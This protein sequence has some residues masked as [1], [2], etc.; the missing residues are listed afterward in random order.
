MNAS[1]RTLTVF[2]NAVQYSWSKIGINSPPEPGGNGNTFTTQD[3]YLGIRCYLKDA[4]GNWH[5][6]QALNVGKYDNQREGIGVSEEEENEQP[7]FELNAYPNPYTTNFT[8]TFDVP[9]ENSQV[10]LDIMNSQ[11]TVL[12]TVVDN[13]HA[14]GKWRYEVKELPDNQGEILFCRLK[15][16]ENYTVKKLVHLNK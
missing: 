14:K 15:I 16:N 2:G 13:P 7:G 9:D 6:T 11:G 8:I 3:K 10:R 12:K 4:T 5:I 1:W